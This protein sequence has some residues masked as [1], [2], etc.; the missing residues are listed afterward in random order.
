MMYLVTYQLNPPRKNPELI[1]ELQSIGEWWHYLDHVWLITSPQGAN[2]IYNRLAPHI[3][4][5]DRILIVEILPAAQTQ[6]WLAQDAWDWINARR[7][8]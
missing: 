7:F 1:S 6:G 3:N 2:D 5:P 8:A 4:D